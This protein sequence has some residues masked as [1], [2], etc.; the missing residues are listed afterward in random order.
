MKKIFLILL[1]PFH[2]LFAEIT[3][4]YSFAEAKAKLDKAGED[5]LVIFDVDDVLI[6]PKDMVCRPR[7]MPYTKTYWDETEYDSHEMNHFIS[8]VI[9]TTEMH[10]IEPSVPSLIEKLKKQKAKVIALTAARTGKFGRIEKMEDWR[11]DE[12]KNLSID[13]SGAFP[14]SEVILFD[15]SKTIEYS[16]FKKGILFL[17]SEDQTKGDLLVRFLGKIGWKPK[18]ILFFD[19]KRRNLVSTEDALKEKNIVFHGYLYKGEERVPGTV[20]EEVAKLQFDHLRKEY[21]W[22][23]DTEAKKRLQQK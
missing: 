6:T 17:G 4:V 15:D 18:E 23:S 11:I 20:D 19:D 12:L 8:I 3:T 10:L 9:T 21:K 1:L 2:A 14:S 7:G 16:L 5:T 22:L 13:F